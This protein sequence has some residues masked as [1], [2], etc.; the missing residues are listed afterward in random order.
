MSKPALVHQIRTELEAQLAVMK[1]AA[2]EAKENATGDETKSDGKYDTRAI[3]A[4]YLAGAQ[5]EQA[6]KLAEAVRLFNAFDPPIY[7]EAEAIGPGALVETEHGG[8]IIYYLLAPAG[9]GH[10]VEYDGFDCTVLSPEARLY[11]ELLEAR[12]GEL[13][14]E[15]ALMVLSVA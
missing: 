9:G 11:Q 5:A 10:T 14:E 1:A 3:E 8:E 15:S 2:T 7:D 12:S 4:G 6:A 13:V